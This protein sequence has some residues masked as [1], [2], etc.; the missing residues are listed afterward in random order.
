MLC[1]V[2]IPGSVDEVRA[3]QC[4][5]PVEPCRHAPLYTKYLLYYLGGGEGAP[6]SGAAI[7][8][9]DIAVWDATTNQYGGIY[10]DQF[11][12]VTSGYA[13]LQALAAGLGSAGML[14]GTLQLSGCA[15][16]LASDPN[17]S[18]FFVLHWTLN[19]DALLELVWRPAGGPPIIQGLPPGQQPVPFVAVGEAD[20][21]PVP[22]P[23]QW[24]PLGDA[25]VPWHSGAMPA[26]GPPC[27]ECGLGAREA[28]LLSAGYAV[29]LGGTGE[30]E[31]S[32]DYVTGLPTL[33]EWGL[34]VLVGLF[35]SVGIALLGRSTAT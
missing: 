17:P 11:F 1:V 28:S 31:V 4:G 20:L 27:R 32:V 26:P 9:A 29:A 25:A 14:G 35:L 21:P 5:T 22:W 19:S 18:V 7:Q 6:T 34:M 10:V 3:A 8:A 23:P 33:T 13:H 2:A 15:C 12:P 16:Q 24:P 30:L